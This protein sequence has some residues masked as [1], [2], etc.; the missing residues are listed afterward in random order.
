MVFPPRQQV[1]SSAINKLRR[2]LL[3]RARNFCSFFPLSPT[4]RKELQPTPTKAHKTCFQLYSFPLFRCNTFC[5]KHFQKADRKSSRH[6]SATKAPSSFSAPFLFILRSIVFR[7]A[8]SNRSQ[9]LFESHCVKSCR[10]KHSRFFLIKLFFCKIN[11]SLRVQLKSLFCN[12]F[13]VHWNW[14]CNIKVI[15]Q[16]ST[17]I[18][19]LFL[20]K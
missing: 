9:L 2:S 19:S 13:A 16:F 5:V 20:W 10:A 11:F 12:I 4:A 8:R 17:H 14:R 7:G 18:S 6:I 15:Y 1:L 3:Q